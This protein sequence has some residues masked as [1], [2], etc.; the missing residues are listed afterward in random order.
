MGRAGGVRGRAGEFAGVFAGQLA[1]SARRAAG[2]TLV[3]LEAAR[4][5]EDIAAVAAH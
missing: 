2:L 4:A 1:E 5:D 3:A